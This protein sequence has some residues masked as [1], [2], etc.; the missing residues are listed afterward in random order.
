MIYLATP[1]TTSMSCEHWWQF[2]NITHSKYFESIFARML[3]DHLPRRWAA[4]IWVWTLLWLSQTGSALVGPWLFEIVFKAQITQI[5]HS[6]LKDR[7]LVGPLLFEI[8]FKAQITGKPIH[9]WKTVDGHSCA[10]WFLNWPLNFQYQ[11]GKRVA[12]TNFQ[13][14][15]FLVGWTRFSFSIM[16]R[17]RTTYT[18][19]WSSSPYLISII[20]EASPKNITSLLYPDMM[21]S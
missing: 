10:G 19:I 12:A 20:Y 14:K 15:K 11:E 21:S 17:K 3:D 18:Y 9:N 1:L 13:W 2:D 6:E 8:L 7:E 4:T 16:R 5:S